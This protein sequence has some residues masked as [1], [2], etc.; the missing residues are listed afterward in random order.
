MIYIY[1]YIYIYIYIYVYVSYI[2]IYI[3]ILYTLDIKC[4][5]CAFT[6]HIEEGKSKCTE[7]S[8][9]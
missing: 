1:M 9:D 6:K 4:V 3:Y 2:Y 5:P 8:P 7:E